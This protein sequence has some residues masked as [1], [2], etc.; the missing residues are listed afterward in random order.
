MY[1]SQTEVVNFTSARNGFAESNSLHQQKIESLCFFVFSKR[2]VIAFLKI[3]INVY[4]L[5]HINKIAHF[6]I[7]EMIKTRTFNGK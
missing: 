6:P 1:R 5:E 4:Q 3:G 2:K 7:D